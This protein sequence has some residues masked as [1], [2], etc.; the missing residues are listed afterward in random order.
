MAQVMW[1]TQIYVYIMKYYLAIQSEILPFATC[2][3]M[4]LG[5]IKSSKINQTEKVKYNRSSLE[6]G[7]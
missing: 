6:W 2:C 7:I 5:G 4:D 1:Y 3:W